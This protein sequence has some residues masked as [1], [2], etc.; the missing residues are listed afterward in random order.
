MRFCLWFNKGKRIMTN[1]HKRELGQVPDLWR[2]QFLFHWHHHH[3][4]A[5]WQM[6]CRLV[7]VLSDI[8]FFRCH[9][10]CINSNHCTIHDG[11]VNERRNALLHWQNQWCPFFL[12]F[13]LD[14][15]IFP[16][17][18]PILKVIVFHLINL[19]IKILTSWYC[20]T[21]EDGALK[22]NSVVHAVRL[23]RYA[24]PMATIVNDLFA[25]PARLF[26]IKTPKLSLVVF[27]SG[28]DEFCF[29][30]GP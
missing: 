10:P 24:Y 13:T 16:Y 28:R 8:F 6:C 11:W 1:L 18:Y 22:W 15:K 12:H 4:Y 5:V 25:I 27:R 2:D 23:W 20:H 19:V 26:T 21:N 17:V 30:N 29:A 3:E 14:V 9:S 7:Y